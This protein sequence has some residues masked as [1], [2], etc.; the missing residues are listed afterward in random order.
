MVGRAH[1][2]RLDHHH[3]H[4]DRSRTSMT[5]FFQYSL[6]LIAASKSSLSRLVS[7]VSWLIKFRAGLPLVFLPHLGSHSI[8][9]CITSLLRKQCLAKLT[10][11]VSIVLVIFG[12]LSYC[13]YVAA[14]LHYS[15]LLAFL[16]STRLTLFLTFWSMS[17]Y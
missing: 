14:I 1:P 8:N 4:V 10:L 13:L 7:S 16:Y 9:L 5:L 11:C 12:M 6:S 17:R 3:H 2:S 15:Q